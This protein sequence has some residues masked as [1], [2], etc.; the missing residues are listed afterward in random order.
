MANQFMCGFVALMLIGSTNYHTTVATSAAAA[1]KVC[2][3]WKLDDDKLIVQ[4]YK[5]GAEYKAKIVWFDDHDDSKELNY[6]TD[7]KNPNPALRSRKLLGMNVLEQLT[8]NQQTNS[9]ENGMIYD[10][11]HGR[12]WNS[13]AYIDKE[14]ALKVKG[15]WHFK[16]IGKTLTFKRLSL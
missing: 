8:Y 6:W 5:E 4:V 3:K 1:E 15:Y 16:F 12:L 7:E 13:S 14:G 9:W 11:K 2:G 10:A